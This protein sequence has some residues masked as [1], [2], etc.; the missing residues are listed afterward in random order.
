MLPLL[1][2]LLL[3]AAVRHCGPDDNICCCGSLHPIPLFSFSSF[4]HD[5][6]SMHPLAV[7]SH[8]QR[9]FSY[10]YTA[11]E[12]ATLFV[13]QHTMTSSSSSSCSN[14]GSIATHRARSRPLLAGS[15]GA[16]KVRHVQQ[17][18]H[19]KVDFIDLD[20]GCLRLKTWPKFDF[21]IAGTT[22]MTWRTLS[23]M[24]LIELRK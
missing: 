5:L 16:S 15:G 1:Q 17:S 11:N 23:S 8:L 10:L 12:P 9:R 22:W 13:I 18:A 21:S 24:Y 19:R 7:R 14:D 2:L 20:L 3:A 6:F 4:E